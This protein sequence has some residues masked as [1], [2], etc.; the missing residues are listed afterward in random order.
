LRPLLPLLCPALFACLSPGALPAGSAFQM[1]LHHPALIP[2]I[3]DQTAAELA[4]AVLVSDR[5]RAELMVNRMRGIDTVLRVSDEAP[6]GLMPVSLELVN[7]TIDDHRANRAANAELLE[8]DDLDPAMRVR[9]QQYQ[10]DDPLELAGA[11]TRDAWMI[12]FARAFNTI[13]EPVG[14]SIGSISMA[15][16]RVGRALLKYAAD[17]YSQ[18][19][20]SLQ[21]RQAL[22]HWKTFIRRNPEAPE[23][24]GLVPRV[25]SAEARWLETQ[26]DRALR[27]SRRAL[28]RGQVRLA[29]IY[30]DR[31]MRHDPEDREASQ[32]RDRAA[33]LLLE[34]REERHRS[35][36]FSPRDSAEVVPASARRLSLALLDPDGDVE[37]AALA[38]LAADEDG[39]LA[40]EAQYALAT[41]DGEAGREVAM[42]DR[43]EDIAEADPEDSNMSRHARAL[44]GDPMRNAY[45]AFDDARWRSH[46][47]R[48]LFVLFGPFYRGLPERRLPA[49]IAL[50]M[51]LPAAAQTL[52]SAPVRL[53]QLPFAET[54]P[55]TRV[56]AI[57]GRR[58]LT[59][60]PE[61]EHADEVRDWL[62]DFEEDRGNAIAVLHLAET[63]E[64][65]DADDMADLREE[66]AHQMV[67]ATRRESNRDLRNAMYRRIASDFPET[68]SG[69]RAGDLARD[70]LEY[71][72]PQQIRLTRGFLEENP[73]V[74]G[75]DGLGL[76]PQLLDDDP[77]NGELHGEGVALLGGRIIEVSFV[78]TSGDPEDP[79]QLRREKLSEDRLA[80]FVSQIQ[81]TTYENAMEDADDT[82]AADAH[83]DAFFERAR[84]GLADQVDRRALAESTYRY[85]GL[86]ERYGMVRGRES[87][88]P[89]DIVLQ[90]NLGDLSLGAFPR[91]RKPRE[92]PDAFLYR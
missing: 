44:V 70:E 89:F 73:Q 84:L 55:R 24:E 61:G 71:A 56:A 85:E 81:E 58:Y 21:Q 63:R 57:H 65:V 5:Q 45:E 13:A 46:L 26:R 92:T 76:K 14:R 47:D 12:E 64:D 38:L 90:G 53:L 41:A 77:S 35:V 54:L 69:Q 34:Q 49:P 59:Q 43:L 68:S 9:L 27:T 3:A 37:G 17:L 7:A 2:D 74:A 42:W 10:D 82:V 20:L 23:V 51:D 39:P 8:R 29:L 6:T 36:A 19:A 30:A 28:D 62:E 80:R 50:A 52:M 86:R 4:N 87:I 67:R 22:A 11:R 15:P 91:I 31:G 60:N 78:N 75:V 32:L 25:E 88:L 1:E 48:A 16:Y 18:E 66:A 79:P 72:T 40:D 33:A 83:R